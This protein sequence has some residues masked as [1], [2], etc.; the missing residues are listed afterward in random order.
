MALYINLLNE[1]A[2]RLNYSLFMIIDVIDR[3]TLCHMTGP[4]L[5]HNLLDRPQDK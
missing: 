5:C 4:Q 1:S 3:L 2:A